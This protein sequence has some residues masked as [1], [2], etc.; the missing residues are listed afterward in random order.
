MANISE[1]ISAGVI[2]AAKA[3][4]DLSIRIRRG[5]EYIVIPLFALVVSSLLFSLFLLALGKSPIEF[6]ELVERGG[7]GTAFS[8]AE[9]AAALGA[10]DPH[11]ARR[12]GAGAHRP[13]HDRR[14]GRAGAR[15]LRRRG[16]RDPAGA[17][18]GA[19]VHR[20]HRD[21]DHR[22]DRRRAVGRPCRLSALCARRQRDDLLAAADLHRHRHHELLR[23]GLAARPHEPQQ[24]VDHADRRGLHGRQD[25]RHRR[26]LGAGRRHR[27]RDRAAHPVVAHDVRLRG[28]DHRRQ[29]AGGE[30]PRACRSAGSSSPAR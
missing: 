14:R 18:P 29:S 17:Q 20:A 8:L 7:F 24:A 23:R 10:A 11:R 19:A 13:H 15:R 16:D 2:A 12:R 27:L 28:A 3:P 9:H 22:H 6:F 30:G 5:A 26:A 21:G 25:S 1:P 4:S